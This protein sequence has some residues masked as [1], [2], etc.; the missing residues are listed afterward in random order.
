MFQWRNHAV[1]NLQ[2]RHFG[3]SHFLTLCTTCTSMHCAHRA[4]FHGE[5]TRYCGEPSRSAQLAHLFLTGGGHFELYTILKC[6]LIPLV[7]ESYKSCSPHIAG[8]C[9]CWH[10]GK[11]H[12]HQWVFVQDLVG[13]WPSCPSWIV[14]VYYLADTAAGILNKGWILDSA[15]GLCL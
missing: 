7:P 3:C 9:S 14:F 12:R 10:C 13:P 2:G 15:P 11:L 1:V 5:I 8:R 6:W 4:C